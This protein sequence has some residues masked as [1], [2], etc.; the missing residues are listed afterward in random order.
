LANAWDV[1]SARSHGRRRI[2]C[3]VATTSA[4]SS[5]GCWVIRTASR[6]PQREMLEFVA[7][8]RARRER[9]GHRRHGIGIWHK[10]GGTWPKMAPRAR[11]R[12]SG[13][14]KS[15]DVT[16]MTR[17]R[18]SKLDCKRKNRGGPGSFGSRGRFHCVINARTD[19]YVMPIGPERNAFRADSR[20]LAHL[21]QSRSRLCF[22]PG[23]RGKETIGRLVREVDAPLTFLCSPWRPDCGGT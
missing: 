18:T 22:A 4:G 6:V 5:G 2:S 19:V 14:T 15:R 7:P 17:A 8:N 13:G 1:I 21:P 23:I 9:S 11:R 20:A 12:R 16:G 3:P 10:S